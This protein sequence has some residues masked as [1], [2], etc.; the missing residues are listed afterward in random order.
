MKQRVRY[1]V[2]L[3]LAAAMSAP[4][5]IEAGLF[6]MAKKAGE[7]AKKKLQKLERIEKE[8][9]RKAEEILSVPGV[10]ENSE[11][12][13]QRGGRFFVSPGGVKSA[14]DLKSLNPRAVEPSVLD[15]VG[16][17]RWEA[18]KSHF[19]FWAG[20]MQ[21]KEGYE[22]MIRGFRERRA[23]FLSKGDL[24]HA[25]VQ[26][27]LI[28]GV[29]A[30]LKGFVE[31]DPAGSVRPPSDLSALGF[32]VTCEGC[33]VDAVRA[34]LAEYGRRLAAVPRQMLTEQHAAEVERLAADLGEIV[35]LLDAGERA[36]AQARM[37]ARWGWI[38]GSN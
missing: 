18:R 35:R 13:T 36:A 19:D 20:W 23:S 25:R 7:E 21:T 16:R 28:A 1:P 37:D 26:E 8:A 2:I 17:L 29:E 4:G 24:E 10:L 12:I 15:V 3:M 6:D 34:S 33:P 14:R 32:D 22:A 5:S 11:L 30:Q 27:Q 38:L 31:A 9:E